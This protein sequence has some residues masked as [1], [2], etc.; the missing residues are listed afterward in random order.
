MCQ[1]C[2]HCIGKGSCV[3]GRT[4]SEVPLPSCLRIAANAFAGV[5]VARAP[6]LRRRYARNASRPS[7][8]SH[9]AERC[10]ERHQGHRLSQDKSGQRVDMPS[11]MTNRLFFRLRPR[12][13]VSH[14]T[15]ASPAYTFIYTAPFHRLVAFCVF[16][17]D[18]KMAKCYSAPGFA[19]IREKCRLFV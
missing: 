16:L 7:T 3:L 5:P 8:P 2:F 19:P 12:R 13:G 11:D 10:S 6:T 18:L 17:I 14:E 9:S 15:V 1:A 4:Q